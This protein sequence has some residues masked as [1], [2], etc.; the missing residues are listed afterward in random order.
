MSHMSAM[1][2]LPGQHINSQL[3]LQLVEH[4]NALAPA[5]M[6]NN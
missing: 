6:A 2:Q 1:Q 4:P 3:H 5:C